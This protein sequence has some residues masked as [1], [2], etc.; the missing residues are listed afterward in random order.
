MQRISITNPQNIIDGTAKKYYFKLRNTGGPKGDKGDKGDTGATG[1]QGPQG[2]AATV[3]VGSTTT[4]PVGYDATVTNSGSIYNAVLDFGIPQGPQGP[5]GAKGDKGDTG[6][7]GDTGPRGPQGE[8]GTNATVYVG[9]TTTT[10]PGTQARVYNSGTD[11]NAVLNFEIPRGDV[12]PQPELVQTTGSSTT[13]AMSQNATTVALNGKQNTLTAGSNIQI[14]SNTISATDTTY[15]AGNGLN[16]NGTEFSADTDVLAT[17]S[18][19][20]N[21]YTKPQTDNLLAPKLEAEVVA[22]LPTTGEE[23]KLYLTPKAHTT[24]TA[25]GNPITATVAEEA[26]AIESFQLDGDTTQQTYSGAQVVKK[27]GFAT[28]ASDTNFWTIANATQSDISSDGFSTFTFSGTSFKNFFIRQAGSDIKASTTYT[29]IIEVDKVSDL[30]FM[31]ITQGNANSDSFPDFTVI[32]LPDGAHTT[33]SGNATNGSVTMTEGNGGNIVLL[34]TTRDEL[35]TQTLRFF[36]SG[37][38]SDGKK[39]RARVSIIEGDHTSDWQNYCGDNWQPYVGVTASPN[40][41]YPQAVNTVTGRQ[42]VEVTGKNLFNLNGDQQPNT[43]CTGT[44]NGQSITITSTANSTGFYSI[45]IPNSSELLGKTVTLSVGDIAAS[46]DVETTGRILIYQAVSTQPNNVGGNISGVDIRSAGSTTFTF[47]DSFLSGRDCFVV[48]LYVNARGTSTVVGEY[49]TYTNIQLELGSTATDYEPYS[50]N[51]YEI[52]LGSIELCKLGTYQD[53]I[54][55]DGGDWKVHKATVKLDFSSITSGTGG[56]TTS[57]NTVRV[58]YSGTVP[59]GAADGNDRRLALS[60][61]FTNELNYSDDIVGFYYTKTQLN[62]WFRVPKTIAT[63]WQGAASWITAH[64][65]TA[66]L[67]LATPTDTTI[68]DQTLIAQLEAVRNATLQASNTITNAAT[69]SNLAGDMEIGYY[70]Y[71]PRNRYDKFIWLDLNNAYEQ[72]NNP[73]TSSTLSTLSTRSL[74]ATTEQPTVTRSLETETITLKKGE[75]EPIEDK[76]ELPTILDE[77]AEETETT[78]PEESDGTDER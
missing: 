56:A 41:D 19:L 12:G 17:K 37:S 23:G 1:P 69:V 74:G 20:E 51:D 38:S 73:D 26:G 3:S 77:E 60:S 70:G 65:V 62:I 33:S 4:L 45:V 13:K 2:N 11:S 52:D 46:S 9:T 68:T 78:E 10:N 49:S 34:G 58:E 22:E 48:V 30:P 32:S 50:S 47:P 5:Q 43:R 24:Q 71:N 35:K 57:E 15:T 75:T 8:R 28:P 31:T 39:I 14:S 63:T 21:Y 42:M 36:T 7:K 55:K 76:T 72:L 25:T 59:A 61:H 67:P 18:D 66:Y 44:I 29:V 16:L 53:Y 6:A 54:Y 64:G 27:Q 40:P